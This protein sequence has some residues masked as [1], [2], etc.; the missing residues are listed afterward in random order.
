VFLSVTGKYSAGGPSRIGG[1][2]E[3]KDFVRRR[4]SCRNSGTADGRMVLSSA[5]SCADV[6]RSNIGGATVSEEG[7]LVSLWLDLG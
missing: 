2:A 7:K 6:E 4:W 1:S 3:T 5:N